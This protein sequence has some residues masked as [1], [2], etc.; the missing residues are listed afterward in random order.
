M[1]RKVIPRPLVVL[2]AQSLMKYT[3]AHGDGFITHG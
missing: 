2:D 1:E 3:V